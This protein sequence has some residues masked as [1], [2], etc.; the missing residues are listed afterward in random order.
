MYDGYK[1][2]SELKPKEIC[3]VVEEYHE[4]HFYRRFHEHI[5]K[6]RISDENLSATLQALVLKFQNNEP[7][8]ILRSFL[9]KRGKDPSAYTFIWHVTRPEP[10]VLRKHCGSNTCAWSDQVIAPSDF[11]K[12]TEKRSRPSSRTTL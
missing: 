4:G 12:N 1:L 7:L 5:P 3:I 6:H 8:T 2:C 10:G 9:N 11:R